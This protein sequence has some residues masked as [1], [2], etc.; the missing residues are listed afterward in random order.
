MDA[1]IWI[2]I[3]VAVV[4]VLA[5]IWLSQSRMRRKLQRKGVAPRVRSYSHRH[6]FGGRQAT[7][8]S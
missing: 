3:V 8:S 1:W 7:R 5:L 2:L 4:V 6:S